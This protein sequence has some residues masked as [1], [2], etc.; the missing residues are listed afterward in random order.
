MEA[1]PVVAVN[2]SGGAAPQSL[3]S[4]G[5]ELLMVKPAGRLSTMEKFVRSVSPGAV[6]SILNLELPP[7]AILEGENDLIPNISAPVTVK[8]AVIGRPFPTP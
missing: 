8:V 2:R 4:G 5:V 1:A 6:I 3:V 7:A